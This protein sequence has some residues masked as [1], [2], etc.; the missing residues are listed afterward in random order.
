MPIIINQI[1]TP[2]DWQEDKIFEKAVK[3]LRSS[4]YKGNVKTAL[5]KT[6]LDARKRNDIHFVH[7]VYAVLDNTIEEKNICAANKQ[8][9]FLNFVKNNGYFLVV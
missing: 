3:I 2:L 7:S 9:T 1:K 5:H 4:G 6:S 8:I